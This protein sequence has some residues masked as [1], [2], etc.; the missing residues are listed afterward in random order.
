MCVGVILVK[1]HQ[2]LPFETESFS[3]LVRHVRDK[4]VFVFEELL[5]AG[6][7]YISRV[8]TKK[9]SGTAV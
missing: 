8:D 5:V 1:F 6:N 7:L 2:N 9:E 4:T 3:K